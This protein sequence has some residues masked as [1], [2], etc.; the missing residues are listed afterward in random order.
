MTRYHSYW[1]VVLIVAFFG[2]RTDFDVTANYE[3]IPV[4]YGLLD[5]QDSVHYLRIQWAYLDKS[6][7][8][9]EQAQIPDSIYYP[10][11]LEVTI[12]PA[13]GKDHFKLD[14]VL[15]DMIGLP[16]EEGLFSTKGH[17]LYR[18]EGQLKTGVLYQL[19]ITNQLTGKTVTATAAMVGPFTSF[20]PTKNYV[21]NWTGDTSDV[22]GFKWNV[23]QDAF[24]F[25]LSITFY[26]YETPSG[27]SDSTLKKL[28]WSILTN[29][30]AN[31]ITQ[32][33]FISYTYPS[34]LFYRYIGNHLETLPGVKRS[35]DKVLFR[36]T[37]GG[38][39]LGQLIANQQVQNGIT[40]GMALERYTN[41]E[42]GYG[43]FSSRYLLEFE[44]PIGHA[45][46]DSL[47][48]GKYTKE[49]GFQ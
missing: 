21:I 24:V 47:R 16:K 1:L 39:E 41:I 4:V 18:F 35:P 13:T 7:S 37:A 15:G 12:T 45:T 31:I 36:L 9:I 28:E 29:R 2:C 46:R 30:L 43:I 32:E 25:D 3:E 23:N 17:V 20:L 22:V 6:T 40:S 19:S 33:F 34:E 10:D 44:N 49:L 27:A 48:E 5:I 14:R 26:Y 42:G 8:A 38:N 11:I